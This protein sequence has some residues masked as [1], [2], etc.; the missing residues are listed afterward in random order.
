MH[1]SRSTSKSYH[2]ILYSFPYMIS[3]LASY[4]QKRLLLSANLNPSRNCLPPMLGKRV[5]MRVHIVHINIGIHRACIC[6]IWFMGISILDYS[7]KCK[8]SC[9]HTLFP[10][11]IIDMLIPIVFFIFSSPT[12]GWRKCYIRDMPSVSR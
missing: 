3:N 2:R 9:Y 12:I 1:L 6:T 5:R 11:Q 4:T 8:F 7:H 10:C